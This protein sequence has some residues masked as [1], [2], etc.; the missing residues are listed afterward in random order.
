[1]TLAIISDIHSNKEALET[2]LQAIAGLPVDTIYCLGDIVGYGPDPDECTQQV[3]ARCALTVRGNHDKAV[4]G[5][6]DLEWFNSVAREAA[7]WNRKNS[8]QETLSALRTLPQGPLLLDQGV[9]IC[10][11]TPMDEDEY[12]LSSAAVEESYRWIDSQRSRTRCCFHG[13]SHLPMVIERP[14]ERKQVQVLRGKEEFRLKPEYTYLINPGSVGQPRDG[15][16]RASFGIFDTESLVYRN[17]RVAYAV[18]ETQRK[19]LKAGLPGELARRLAD[20]R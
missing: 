2:V 4:V 8:S 14:G 18:K 5:L 1:V 19:I 10:H 6:I 12:M 9:V 11:G 3:L 16:P 7:L 20:G 17:L 13:H 15:N